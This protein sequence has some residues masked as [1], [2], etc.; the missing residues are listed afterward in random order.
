MGVV[1]SDGEHDHESLHSGP[2]VSPSLFVSLMSGYD[3]PVHEF[4]VLSIAV[5][6]KSSNS[7]KSLQAMAAAH[8]SQQ[9]TVKRQTTLA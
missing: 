5:G 7:S 3:T 9:V 6:E 2:F 1:L 4:A 8:V